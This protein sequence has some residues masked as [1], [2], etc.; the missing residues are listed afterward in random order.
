M[1]VHMKS[2]RKGTND[3]KFMNIFTTFR[4]VQLHQESNLTRDE[5]QV[6]TMRE[7]KAQGC[8]I[9]QNHQN[10]EYNEFL[11]LGNIVNMSAISDFWF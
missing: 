7:P 11:R 8:T 2:V 5:W 6:I 9:S 1:L 10:T 4:V 3:T